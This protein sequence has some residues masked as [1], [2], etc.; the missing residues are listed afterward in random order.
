MNQIIYTPI[1]KNDYPAIKSLINEAF[2]FYKFIEDE[3]FLDKCLTIYLRMCLAETTFS[4]IARKDGKIIGVILGNAKG[5]VSRLS[6][7]NHIAHTAYHLI[8]LMFAKKSSKSML[9]QYLKVLKTYN[10]FLS[11]RKDSFQG[12]IELFIVSK[13]SRGL[14]LGKKLVQHLIDYMKAN[15][16][17]DIYL[18]TDDKCNYGFYDHF[19]FKRLDSKPVEMSFASSISTLNVFL[20]G[21]SL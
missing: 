14:G 3:K 20:Y 1:T 10:Q 4:S 21:L 5:K 9:N 16:I 19:G 17:S 18:F 11:P 2:E 8:Q 15:D 12:S 6:T 7:L 13:E